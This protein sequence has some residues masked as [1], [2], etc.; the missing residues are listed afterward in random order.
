MQKST[1][2]TDPTTALV[3]KMGDALLH[4]YGENWPLRLLHH[5][6]AISMHLLSDERELPPPVLEALQTNHAMLEA[7]YQRIEFIGTDGFAKELVDSF[8]TS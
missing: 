4:I 3:G 2:K 1:G 5:H 6:C 7:I 8:Q